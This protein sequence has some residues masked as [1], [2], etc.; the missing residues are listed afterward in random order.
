MQAGFTVVA[1]MVA[2]FIVAFTMVGAEVSVSQSVRRS[3]PMLQPV[4]LS[5]SC[6]TTGHGC[7]GAGATNWVPQLV[8][9]GS[10]SGGL[11]AV[12]WPQACSP[13]VMPASACRMDSHSHFNQLS[14]T[15][16]R[17]CHHG[18]RLG[19]ERSCRSRRNAQDRVAYAAHVRR[20]RQATL[21]TSLI[22]FQL[23]HRKR[24]QARRAVSVGRTCSLPLCRGSAHGPDERGTTGS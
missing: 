8:Q 4:P 19:V 23:V 1:S 2:A 10:H 21:S 22:S 3:T 12:C 16:E 11:F 24:R 17:A 6:T 9:E 14:N 20:S 13:T 5:G 15:M 7:A 18:C